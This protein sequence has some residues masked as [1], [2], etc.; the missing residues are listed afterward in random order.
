M[1][2]REQRREEQ[3]EEDEPGT[4]HTCHETAE[5][6]H[7]HQQTGVDAE[8]ERD[9]MARIEPRSAPLREIA[10][11]VAEKIGIDHFGDPDERHAPGGD[12]G[13]I[14]ISGPRTESRK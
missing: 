11:R 1:T 5:R 4:A 2:C 7:G 8:V 10:G 14:H 13:K 12:A 6:G 9:D 3:N